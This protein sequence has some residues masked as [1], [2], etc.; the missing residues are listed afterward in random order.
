MAELER[1]RAARAAAEAAL[2]AV[3]HHYGQRPEFVVLG[4]LGALPRGRHRTLRRRVG[5]AGSRPSVVSVTAGR[6]SRRPT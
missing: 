4:G 5:R 2:V 1:S 3:I 6:G